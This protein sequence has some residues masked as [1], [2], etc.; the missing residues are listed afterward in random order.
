MLRSQFSYHLP[1]ELIA[2]YPSEQRT[3]SRLLSLDGNSGELGHHQFVEI[4]D[5]LQPSDLLVL[6]NTRVMQARLFGQKTTGGKLE[7][8][9]ERVVEPSRALAKVRNSRSL[10]MGSSFIIAD[11]VEVHVDGAQEGLLM[12]RLEESD[13]VSLMA[14]HGH[15]PLPPYIDRGDEDIDAS[16]YQTVYAQ[17]DGAVAAPTA[18]L[19]FDETLLKEIRDKGIDI[20]EITLH[21]GAGTFEPVRVDDIAEHTMHAETFEVSET[22]CN[23]IAE[24]RRAGGRVIAV[25]TTSVRALESAANEAGLTKPLQG[26]TNIFITPGYQFRCIDAMV[27]NFH[28]PE[29]TLLMLISAFAGYDNVMRAYEEAVDQRYRFF[30]YG[31]AMFVSRQQ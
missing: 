23:K 11:K 26:E 3:S 4:I 7:I 8:L 27:T 25:G 15:M 24:T 1:N 16:R 2:Q 9:V 20:A 18:G 14:R 5:L 13:W 29:S 21:V 17:H 22:V 28:L 12:L 6:N 30:S 31:D 10:K 19:H